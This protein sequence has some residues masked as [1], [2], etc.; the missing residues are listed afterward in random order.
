[1]DWVQQT[2]LSKSS[3]QVALNLYD[4]LAGLVGVWVNRKD[5]YNNPKLRSI[6]YYT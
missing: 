6:L 2:I 3:I 4:P 5:Q 1:M